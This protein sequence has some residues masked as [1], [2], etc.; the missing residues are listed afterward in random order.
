MK[1]KNKVKDPK[2]HLSQYEVDHKYKIAK[3]IKWSGYR[4]KSKAIRKEDKY[5]E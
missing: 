5:Y 2:R 4:N 1:D 3:L